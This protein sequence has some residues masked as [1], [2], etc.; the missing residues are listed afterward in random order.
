MGNTFG[1]AITLI[2]LARMARELD[3]LARA[4][5][6]YAES[7]SLRWD[8]G[9]NVSVESCLRGLARIALLAGQ[10]E[11]ATRLFGAGE[12]LR[13]AIG[14]DEARL[15]P[16]AD[17]LAKAREAL[18]E[19]VF[20]AAWAAGRAL[21]LADAVAEALAVPQAVS[22][23]ESSSPK[24]EYGLTDREQ[25]VL[26]LLAAGRSN[27]DIAEE[28]FIS[29]RTVTT[30]VSNIFTKLGVA[31]RTEATDLAHRRGLLAAPPTQPARR[32]THAT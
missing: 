25:D 24:K 6:L 8:H 19:S 21:S 2:N 11:R 30:H 22:S 1:T 29:V 31:N 18:G 5:A 32:S 3:D 14:A 26:R 20:A 12:A 10:D 9:D 16:T 17:E 28:L 4:A 23:E 27:P 15:A 7:L 13:E